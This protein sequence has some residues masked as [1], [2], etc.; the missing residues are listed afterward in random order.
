MTVETN[1]EFQ[2][3][4]TWEIPFTSEA[5]LASAVLMFA[6]SQADV[7]V[8]DLTDT[9]SPSIFQVDSP[10]TSGSAVISPELQNA[11]S[12]GSWNYEIRADLGGLSPAGGAHV[13]AYGK[14]VVQASLFAW[15]I[16]T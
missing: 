9:D 7:I 16:V 11:I 2:M 6:L 14:I 5:N 4:E 8:L 1:Y 13:L 10:A 15:P 12:P 3:R